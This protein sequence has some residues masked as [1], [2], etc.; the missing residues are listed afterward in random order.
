D[1]GRPVASGAARGRDARHEPRRPPLPGLCRG[2]EGL[3][4]STAAPHEAQLRHT[5]FLALP[6]VSS[7]RSRR[8][9]RHPSPEESRMRCFIMLAVLCLATISAG[10]APV[11]GAPDRGERTPGGSVDD[12]GLE[13]AVESVME[14]AGPQLEGALDALA[15]T[16]SDI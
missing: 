3:S 11:P 15:L 8:S 14:A 6:G 9:V 1:R 16:L 4:R 7:S 13:E 12:S 5:P 2:G 10:G